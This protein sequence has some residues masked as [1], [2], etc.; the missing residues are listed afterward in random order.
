MR[1]YPKCQDNLFKK[2]DWIPIDLHL[3]NSFKKFRYKTQSISLYKENL[4][5]NYTFLKRIWWKIKK[6]T[7]N[8]KDKYKL[9]KTSNKNNFRKIKKRN[10]NNHHKTWYQIEL[11]EN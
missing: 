11:D 3:L 1:S 4:L 2:P 7:K 9:N 10:K 6:I 5:N 8:N